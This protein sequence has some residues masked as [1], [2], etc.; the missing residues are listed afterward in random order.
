[1]AFQTKI[2]RARFVRSGLTTAQVQTI[3]ETVL[4]SVKGRI[5]RGVNVNDGPAKPLK[6]AA[7]GRNFGYPQLKARKGL[8]PF[9]D[10][11]FRGLT[12]RS[13]KVLTVS[14][15]KIT[16]GF[17]TSEA[18]RIAHALQA[19]ER[20]FGIAPSDR[21]V[22]QQAVADALKQSPAAKVSQVA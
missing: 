3:G 18:D 5:A 15:N 2:Q 11:V 20:M 6:P 13:L 12:M 1:M 16:I 19:G 17:A 21:K 4:A 8:Q 14:E 10:W 7:P 22:L 9:R